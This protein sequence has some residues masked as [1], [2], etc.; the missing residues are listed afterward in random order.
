MTWIIYALLTAV[1]N[2]ARSVASKQS[3]RHLDE[4][5]VSWFISILPALLLLPVFLLGLQPVPAL[6]EMFW[7]VLISDCLLSAIATVWSTK[8][9]LKSDL[10]VTTPLVAF[11][12]LFMLV[13][14]Y[15]MLREA[16]NPAGLVG[17]LLVVGGAYF[18]NIRERRSGWRAPFKALVKD[19]GAR[20][21]LGAAFVWSVT[22]VMD[23][24]AMQ[25]SAPIFFVM[26]ED[27]LIALFILPYA[28]KGLRQHRRQIRE[29]RLQLAAVGVFSMLTLVCQMIALQTALVVY[30]VAI[31]RLSILLSIILGGVVFKEK[32]IKFKLVGG[33]IMVAGVIFLTI[34]Q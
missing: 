9:L 27:F 6:G 5:V 33:T 24:I 3:L 8:A 31:K 21:M 13:T 1:F 11:T 15:L 23:K 17:V 28:W 10:S 34:L 25:A 22:G 30:V 14:G 26:A 12:P 19:E 2:A 4:Y 20:L 32:D 29:E 7:P 18:L 16:P